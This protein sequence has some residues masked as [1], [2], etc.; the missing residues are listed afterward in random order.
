MTCDS[1]IS[2]ELSADMTAL[3]VQW[4]FNE[5]SNFDP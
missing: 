2:M 5:V 1:K 3:V 4:V